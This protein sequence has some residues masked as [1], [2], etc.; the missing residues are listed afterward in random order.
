MNNLRK[1]L[2]EYRSKIPPDHSEVA[3]VAGVAALACWLADYP[4]AEWGSLCD[5]MMDN[6]G[7]FIAEKSKES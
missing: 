7:D 1:L 2:H 3:F 4:E 5:A 6:V